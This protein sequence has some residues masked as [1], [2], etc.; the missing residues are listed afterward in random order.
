MAPPAR[1]RALRIA[2]G[3]VVI[4]AAAATAHGLFEVAVASRVPA[5]IAWLYPVI[6]D[7]LA[8]VAY[9]ATAVLPHRGAR[10][11]AW[12][13]V[14][15]AAGLSGLAQAAFLAG[16]AAVTA[17][18]ALRF[19]VGYWP[20]IAAAVAAHLIYLIMVQPAAED[21]IVDDEQHAALPSRELAPA[22]EQL[23]PV[24]GAEHQP[25]APEPEPAPAARPASV[26]AG[27]RT[28]DDI[29]EEARAFTAREGRPIRSRGE[30]RRVTSCGGERSEKLFAQHVDEQHARQLRAVP[31]G[32]R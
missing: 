1:H 26:R 7:G 9:A 23:P 13:V 17:P 12:S 29:L 25:A 5:G 2:A 16:D 27:R 3:I 8:L 20:A 24:A 14:V 21:G 10:A 4:G 32:A 15:L 30:F 31:G 6:T 18:A 28:D 19:G 22:V 11:Y